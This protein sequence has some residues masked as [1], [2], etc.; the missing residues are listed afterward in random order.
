MK[1]DSLADFSRRPFTLNGETRDVFVAG[2][3][4]GVIVMAEIPGITPE[5]ARFARWVRD[6]GFTVYMP[7][8]FGDPGRPASTAYVYGVIAKLCIGREFHALKSNSASPITQWLRALARRAHEECGG[9][10]VGAIGM[11][12]TGNFAMSLMLEPAM[13]APVLCQ[14][15]LPGHDPSGLH[16]APDDL[17][18]VKQRM[19]AEDLTVLAYRFEGDALCPQDRFDAYEAALGDRF[20]PEIIKDQHAN[21]NALRKKPHSVVT[22]HLIDEA[23]QPT[24]KAVDTILD[25]FRRRLL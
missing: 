18:K 8:M 5:V 3:G 14:P 16:I 20:V 6:A 7:Q 15:S 25:F 9:K 23:G 13:L 2:A 21:P 17:A 19:E 22:A 24:R 11:C 4:P 12:L 10:G 1:Q